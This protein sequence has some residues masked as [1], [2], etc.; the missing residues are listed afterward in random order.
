MDSEYSYEFYKQY[1]KECDTN[2]II[3]CHFI[4]Q[5][6]PTILIFNLLEKSSIILTG[7]R[8]G[9]MI[10][11][12]L[13]FYIMYIGKAINKHFDNAFLKNSKKSIGVVTFGSPTFLNNLSVG[14]KMKKLAP[15]FYHIKEE[16]DFIP[17]V[18][19]FI[20]LNK[21]NISEKEFHFLNKIELNIREIDSLKEY[22]NKINFDKDNLNDYTNKYIR[23]PFGYYFM[24]KTSD[25]SLISINEYNFK[26][27]YYFKY[28][29]STNI[30]SHL[31]IYKKL[32]S[33][34]KF[35]KKDLEFLESKENQLEFIKIIRR[36]YESS[37]DKKPIMKAIIKIEL[38][39]SDN[40][41][42]T[43]DVIQKISL[44]SPDNREIIVN[45]EDIYYDNDTD[46]TA[47]INNFTDNLN[48]NKAIITNY[49]SG[50]IKIKN[51]LNFQGSGPTR[52][53]LYDNLEK[54][55]LIP[56]FKLFEILYISFEKEEEYNR[57]K[58][59]NFG[60]NFEALNILKPFEKQI[61]ILNELLLFTRPDI[62]AN[63]ESKFIDMYINEK[64]NE[65]TEDKKNNVIN[66]IKDNLKKY[67]KHAIILQKSSKI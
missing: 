5:K 50:K 18:I 54:I 1:I 16:F 33:D 42:I 9:G 40:N 65:L 29:D 62:I 6:L 8:M 20:S 12:S 60:K 13:A 14:Y 27:F 67:Y 2:I 46:I 52:K 61:K 41:N 63:K 51:I 39:K 45:N 58:E 49:F 43:P 28:F 23:I 22:L 37:K 4:I 66:N 56:F 32:A 15:Y 25:F 34:A 19:D 47:Y 30:T 21:S 10:A 48:I 36:N 44:F 7:K 38:A 24:M 11:S 55:F 59:A 53:M 35:N 64:K 17:V 3:P 57:L 26:D 31:K